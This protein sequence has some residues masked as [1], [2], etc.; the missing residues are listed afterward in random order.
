MGNFGIKFLYS[1]GQRIMEKWKP[2]EECIFTD[3]QD[4][5][6]SGFQSDG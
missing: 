5:A 2:I 3:F 6:G 4:M 1:A